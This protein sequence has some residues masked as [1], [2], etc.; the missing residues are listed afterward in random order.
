MMC[1]LQHFACVPVHSIWRIV[2]IGTPCWI[3]IPRGRYSNLSCALFV[4]TTYVHTHAAA[5][6]L[7]CKWAKWLIGATNTNNWERDAARVPYIVPQFA[8]RSAT[9]A[10]S[11]D[12]FWTGSGGA[13][14]P[15]IDVAAQSATRSLG[16]QFVAQKC[17]PWRRRMQSRKAAVSSTLHNPHV[18]FAFE[19]TCVS[20]ADCVFTGEI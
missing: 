7:S 2:S 8:L 10:N 1:V 11:S 20:P 3:F 9:R 5:E 4:C 14:S 13:E 19:I 17:Q 18:L 12:G 16:I 6:I 15:R